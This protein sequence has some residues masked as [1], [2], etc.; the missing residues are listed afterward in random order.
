MLTVAGGVIYRYSHNDRRGPGTNVNNIKLTLL[1]QRRNN[2]LPIVYRFFEG[3]GGGY[4]PPL[5]V[6]DI[7]GVSYRGILPADGVRRQWPELAI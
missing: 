7:S 1:R 2:N 5:D 6:C 4:I 3:G